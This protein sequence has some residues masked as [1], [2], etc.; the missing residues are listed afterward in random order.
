MDNRIQIKRED[1]K[2][3][4]VVKAYC[5]DKKQKMLML[6]IFLFSLCGFAI[7]TQFFEDYDAGT[8]VFFG[9]YIAFWLFF[10]FF[11]QDKCIGSKVEG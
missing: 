2:I 7:L 4:V 3:E 10:E 6:W 8:K 5:D 1:K 11:S 9:V